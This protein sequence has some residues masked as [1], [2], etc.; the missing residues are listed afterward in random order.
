MPRLSKKYPFYPQL[1]IMDCGPTCLRMI[2]RFYGK[3]Y[4]LPTL[5]ARTYATRQG[6]SM[7]GIS[8]AAESI[9]FRTMGARLSLQQLIEDMPMPC[10]LHWKQ[11]HFV[12]CYKVI[13]Q[14]KGYR[15]LI[16]DPAFELITYSEAEFKSGWISTKKDNE[17]KGIALA[18]SVTPDFYREEDEK[19][20]KGRSLL[21]FFS[22]LLPFKKP[23]LLLLFSLLV[24]S[25]LQLASPF[26]T[27]SMVDIG[28]HGRNL[29]FITLI[30]LSQLMIAAS[31]MIVGFIQ[32]WLSMHINTRIN[33][34]LISDFLA[35]LMRLPI[36]FFDSKMTGDIMQR[37][38]DHGRIEAL[39]TGSSI[40]VLFSFLN[41]FIF[42][43]ILAYY[44]IGIL[45]I[46]LAGNTLYVLWVL[47]FMRYRRVLDMRRFA[48]ASGEQSNLIQL[49]TGMQEIKL[50]NCEYRKRWQWEHIQV[51]LFKIGIKGMAIGQIQSAGLFFLNQT[52]NI[53]IT[54]ISAKAVVEG[55]M[56]LGMMMSLTYIIGQLSGPISSFLG[57]AT[58]YQDAKISLE[59][60]NEI[61]AQEDE[62]ETVAMKLSKIPDDHTLRLENVSFSYDGA[63]RDYVL[64][65]ISLTIPA[66][67]VTAI[68]GSS[69]S[70]KTT[71]L[72]LLLG[73]YEPN[74]GKVLVGN[75]PLASINPHR[76]RSLTGSVMQEGFLFSES[77]AD[78]IAISDEIPDTD[79]LMEATKVANIQEYIDSLPLGYNTQIGAEG[80][81]VSQGQKQ[82]ILIARAVYKNPEFLFLDEATNS[83]DATNE[84][85][86]ME[87]LT[88]YYQGK[89]VVIVAHRLSTVCNAD[90]IIVLE[91][92]RVVE[93]GTHKELVDKQGQYYKLVKNQL[94][95]G[96]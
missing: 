87:N 4:S 13:R 73:F 16:G 89:T 62:N 22:Y 68:V 65:D 70:G 34:S 29:T 67:K 30:L 45:I 63:E 24:T 5:R 21:H 54:F 33:I 14:R 3:S 91:H 78:N 53:I 86:I 25:I 35:K 39:L 69:G 51:K 79:R 48:Q 6:V 60:L 20:E 77:I 37:I 7:L 74:K 85:T 28:I 92:G 40:N 72:K 1:D 43:F 18:L 71:L 84:R 17:E 94:E 64:D 42:G 23:L 26:L 59:R 46:F 19:E 2:A 66:N 44:N 81:G 75:T 12:V 47:L 52:T 10:I 15:F 11:N 96:L 95:L 93:E 80:S 56:T 82:R 57:L 76:W 49:I 55:Q 58:Q 83:L 9:G 8:E 50:N 27:Q 61:H 88:S 41:F 31:Q 90:K 32:S 36:R 38:G